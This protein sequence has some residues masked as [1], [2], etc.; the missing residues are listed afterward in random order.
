MPSTLTV[1][2]SFMR[3]FIGAAAPCFAL[4][5]VE[6]KGQT[7]GFLALRP[8]EEILPGISDSGFS[9]G[10]SL[11]DNDAF[12][13]LQ[14]AFQFHG[15][16]T[17]NALLNPNHPLVRAVLDKMV[18]GGDYFFFTLA[19]SGAVA[20]FRTEIGQ[21]TRSQVKANLSR[22]R[23]ST[24]TECQYELALA[25]FAKNPEP[26]GTLLHWVCR[27]NIAYL[28]LTHDRLDLNPA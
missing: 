6:E 22:I 15:F 7:C 12:E 5:L 23:Q 10:H 11:Y 13:V 21:D 28:D 18:E 16:Q 24:I 3:E 17:Y 19:E 26:E 20:A 2:R 27:D 25:S 1:N 4:G 8:E 14:F 9:F